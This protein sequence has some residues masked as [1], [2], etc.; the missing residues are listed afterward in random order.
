M[1]SLNSTLR[2]VYRTC[3]D[4]GVLPNQLSCNKLS[5]CYECFCRMVLTAGMLSFADYCSEYK[6]VR[7]RCGKVWGNG[8]RKATVLALPASC[9]PAPPPQQSECLTLAV[10]RAG[11]GPSPSA[12][13]PPIPVVSTETQMAIWS[14]LVACDTETPAF[15]RRR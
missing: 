2:D 9:V 4:T 12:L 7:R 3:H 13:R 14:W 6:W 5:I 15:A 11:K 10:A 1:P 8:G